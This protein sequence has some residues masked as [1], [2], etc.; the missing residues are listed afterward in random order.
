MRIN[1]VLLLNNNYE[2]LN[3]C[4]LM[5]A[6]A[7]M[8][9]GKV[10]ILH[11]NGHV[12]RTSSKDFDAPSVIRLRYY[13]KRPMPVLRLSKHSVLARDAYT[14]QYCGVSSR[15]LTIDHIIPR[16]MG[17]GHNWE[18]VVAC[19]R[20]CNLRKGDKRP[21]HVNMRLLRRPKRPH[22]VPFIPLPTYM[23]ADGRADWTPYLPVFSEF[24][25]RN[26]SR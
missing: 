25:C 12:I 24:R 26:D 14:C 2:P 21:K 4:T 6:V 13:V 10:E 11:R 15:D 9:K 19:C 17:G 18:N 1:D 7:L 22:Y 3:V 5:R 23:R 20:R 8:L 16:R